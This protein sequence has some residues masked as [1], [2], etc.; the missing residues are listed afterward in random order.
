MGNTPMERASRLLGNLKLRAV[1]KAGVRV[2]HPA[3]GA[4]KA[5]V[6]AKLARHAKPVWLENGKLV[7]EVED[8][9]WQAQLYSLHG[10]MLG[11][12]EAVVG[13]G[14]IQTLEFRVVPPRRAPQRATSATPEF[15]LAPPPVDE[16]DTIEDPILRR[17]YRAAR[18]KA[19]A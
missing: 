16:A 14:H 15:G 13:P 18:R 3:P 19:T 6:G 11:R 7:V 17:L 10:Q 8:A 12:L 9:V 4:W 5:A 2:Y 1:E